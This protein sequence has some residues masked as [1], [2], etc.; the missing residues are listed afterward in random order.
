MHIRGWTVLILCTLILGLLCYIALHVRRVNRKI[1][2]LD[3][4]SDK[5]AMGEARAAHARIDRIDEDMKADHTETITL[6][7]IIGA[8]K[9]QVKFLLH[10]DISAELARQADLEA[11]R[12]EGK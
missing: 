4:S 10:K 9:S 1:D 3:L 12:G 11:K 8:V 2:A 7:A 5:Y 6:R